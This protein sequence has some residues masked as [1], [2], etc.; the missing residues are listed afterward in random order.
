[1]CFCNTKTLVPVRQG[2]LP[3]GKSLINPLNSGTLSAI[4]EHRKSGTFEYCLMFVLKKNH[5][6]GN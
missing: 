3:C 1:M 4:S 6:L 2:L 5:P